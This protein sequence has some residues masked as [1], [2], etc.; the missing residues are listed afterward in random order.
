MRPT[1]FGKR[2]SLLLCLCSFG[3]ELRAPSHP[4]APSNLDPPS[5]VEAINFTADGLFDAYADSSDADR[6]FTGK[7]L[8]VEG[9]IRTVRPYGGKPCVEFYV[10]QDKNA[11]TIRCLFGAEDEADVNSLASGQTVTI[12]GTCVGVRDNRVTLENCFVVVKSS[13]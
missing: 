5:R 10:T 8:R 9:T 2:C 12:R 11:H 7:L 1:V 6:R 13:R 3:C 4:A